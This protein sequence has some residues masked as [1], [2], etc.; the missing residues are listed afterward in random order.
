MKVVLIPPTHGVTMLVHKYIP[1]HIQKTV[2]DPASRFVTIQCLLLSQNFILV[3]LYGPKND[4]P[5]FNKKLFLPICSLH[6]D[7]IIGG[8]FICT[9][10]DPQ[11]QKFLTQEV[12][13]SAWIK[14]EHDLILLK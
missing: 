14:L 5:H 2:W 1:L 11:V 3:H 7:I 13:V 10:I 8:D 9:L 12:S 4:D 6:G